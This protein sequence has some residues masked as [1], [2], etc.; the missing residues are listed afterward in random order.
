M[1]AHRWKRVMAHALRPD[2]DLT[3]PASPDAPWDWLLMSRRLG[4]DPPV[5]QQEVDDLLASGK[6]KSWGTSPDD[7]QNWPWRFLTVWMVE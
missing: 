4:I 5:T 2:G 3:K 6:A 7:A 1:T